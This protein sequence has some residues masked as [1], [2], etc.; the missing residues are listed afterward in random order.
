MAY[1]MY[2]KYTPDFFIYK[3][4]LNLILKVN[5]NKLWG[6]SPQV[7]PRSDFIYKSTKITGVTN[8]Q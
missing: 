7:N 8:T 3:K 6:E 1:V 4:V 5:D 2:Q